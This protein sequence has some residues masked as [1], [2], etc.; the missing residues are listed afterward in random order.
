MADRFQLIAIDRRGFG[1]STAPPDLNREVADLVAVRDAL[2]LD[3]MVMVGMSQ[4]GRVALHFALGY[5][6]SVAAIVLQGTPL[7]GFLPTPRR[8]D[9]IPL[10]AFVALARQGRLDRMK[11]LWRAHPL[12]RAGTTEAQEKID[13][14]LADYEGRDLIAAAPHELATIADDLR[15]V[16]APALVVTGEQDTAGRKLVGDALAYGMVHSRR[17]TIAGAGHLCNLSHPA[18]FNALLADFAASIAG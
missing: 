17:A 10:S 3:R 11:E 16:H 4:G 12:M 13:A 18:E 8:E 7:D 14:M 5:P 6:E 2:G 15:A 1:R 9:A